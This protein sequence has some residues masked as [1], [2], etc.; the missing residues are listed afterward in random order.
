MDVED[1][2]DPLEA[3]VAEADK[4]GVA[5]EARRRRWPLL[6]PLPSLLQEILFL[7]LQTV[8]NRSIRIFCKAFSSRRPQLRRKP[9][10]PCRLRWRH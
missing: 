2:W 8:F 10:R 7:S 6:P 9:P 3:V 1:L 4:A 5:V